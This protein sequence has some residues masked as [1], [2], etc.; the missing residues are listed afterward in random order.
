MTLTWTV[1]TLVW[2]VLTLSWS[3]LARLVV[4]RGKAWRELRRPGTELSP[5]WSELPWVLLPRSLLPGT[6]TLLTARAVL[7]RS[8]RAVLLW[9]PRAVLLRPPRAILRRHRVA[10]LRLLLRMLSDPLRVSAG[11]RR[12]AKLRRR[13]TAGRGRRLA[14]RRSVLL[15]PSGTLLLRSVTLLR[16]WTV[17]PRRGAV[18]LRRSGT[19]GS[20]GRAAEAVGGTAIAW[21]SLRP[22]SALAGAPWCR[23]SLHRSALCWIPAAR[24]AGTAWPVVPVGPSL[25]ARA[26]LGR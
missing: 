13:R 9:S 11:P 24:A 6:L 15:R 18:L 12:R 8:P 22:M 1:L 2:T 10:G 16:S 5:A 19:A 7:L 14:R 26:T 3:V 23:L 25:S 21:T 17:L 4:A 20:G